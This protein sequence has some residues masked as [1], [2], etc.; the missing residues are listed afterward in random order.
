MNRGEVVQ[1]PATHPS[2]ICGV[3][4]SVYCSVF[5]PL[6]GG[7]IIKGFGEREGKGRRKKEKQVAQGQYMVSDTLCPA[8][9]DCEL[10]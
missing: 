7:G 6:V 1:S 4:R 10:E 5:H 3:S 8:L 9:S 2:N